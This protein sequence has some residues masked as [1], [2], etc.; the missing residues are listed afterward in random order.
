MTWYVALSYLFLK[1][2]NTT[3]RSANP[4]VSAFLVEESAQQQQENSTSPVLARAEPM[5]ERVFLSSGSENDESS[6]VS[7]LQHVR[8]HRLRYFELGFFL[9]M[10]MAVAIY[11]ALP[12]LPEETGSNADEDVSLSEALRMSDEIILENREIFDD[13]I[14]PSLSSKSR[15]AIASSNSTSPQ[16]LAFEWLVSYHDFVKDRELGQHRLFQRYALATIYYATGGGG[17]NGTWFNNDGWLYPNKHECNWYSSWEE[18]GEGACGNGDIVYNLDLS[19][20]G[21]AGTIPDEINLLTNLG[22]Q[23]HQERLGTTFDLAIVWGS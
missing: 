5:S 12:P 14:V 6:P 13:L 7:C 21:L 9:V 22:K 4:L 2:F 23:Q 17:E 3:T 11:F 1:E 15:E 8:K 10:V 20:N 19:D 16:S 18:Q